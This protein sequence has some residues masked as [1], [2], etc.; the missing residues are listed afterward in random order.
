M[1][2][3]NLHKKERL[4]NKAFKKA[5]ERVKKGFFEGAALA[6]LEAAKLVPQDKYPEYIAGCLNNAGSA[7]LRAKKYTEAEN[8]LQDALTRIKKILGN[9]H[10][11]LA[12]YL[13]NL[14]TL[15]GDKGELDKADKYFQRAKKLHMEVNNPVAEMITK[16]ESTLQQKIDYLEREKL[17]IQAALYQSKKLD[18]LGQM[19]TMMAHNMNQ[20]IGVIRMTTSGALSDVDEKLFD[21]TTELKPLLEK[22][23]SQTER[24]SQIMGNFRNFARGDRTVL[25]AVNLNEVINYIYQLLFDAQYQ[26]DNIVLQK[27]LAESPIAHSNE[28]ALQEMLISLLSN[29]REAVKDKAIKQVGINSWQQDNQ[30]GFCVEDNGDGISQENLPKLFTPFLSS[31][32]EGMGLGLYFCREIAKDLGG[33]IEYYP[34]SLGGAGFKITLPAQQDNENDAPI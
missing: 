5:E 4:A 15:Y 19:A 33:S 32:N 31:K 3:D 8:C 18:Y 27:D 2:P 13:N 34:A 7:Y 26:L 30:A 6:F 16:N 11:D 24:L 9:N 1:K 22:I 14:G 21:S 29:A 17:E 20:P 23:L 10:P 25:S 12:G 28:W